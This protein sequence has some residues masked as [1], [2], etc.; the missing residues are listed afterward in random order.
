VGGRGRERSRWGG[1]KKKRVQAAESYLKIIAHPLRDG[2]LCLITANYLEFTSIMAHL[3]GD[4]VT[5]TYSRRGEDEPRCRTA[6]PWLCLYR[7]RVCVCARVCAGVRVCAP[8]SSRSTAVFL[9]EEI[10]VLLGLSE[11]WDRASPSLPY[12]AA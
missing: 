6:F 11:G 1:E 3:N 7:A 5:S 8:V 9:G 10:V 12:R 2:F 4:Y